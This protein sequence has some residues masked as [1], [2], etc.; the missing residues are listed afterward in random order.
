[1]DVCISHQTALS[2]LLRVPNLRQPGARQ[3][4]AAAIPERVP[5]SDVT[6]KLLDA[7]VGCLPEGHG[8]LDVLV[9]S[10][11]GRYNTGSVRAHLCTTKLPAGSFIPTDAMGVE[12]HVCAPE[13]VFLQMAGEV[14][15]DHLIY[16]GFALC[17][18]FRLDSW[19]P[20]GCVYREGYDAPLTT[21]DRMRAYL[22]RLPEGT[23]NRAVAL[24]ALQHVRAGARSPRE[25]GIAMVIGL[26][27]SL[28]GYSLG[29]TS[30]NPEIRVY[31]GIDSRGEPRWVTR[32]PDILVVAH[33][34]SGRERR[35]G[36]DFDAKSTHGDPL[37]VR[38]DVDRRNLLA[39]VATFT[40]FT[41]GS[42]QVENY[43][44][45]CREIDRIRRALGQRQKPRLVGNADSE[46]NRRLVAATRSRQFDLWNRVLGAECPQL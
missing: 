33:D 35:V 20:G 1:M 14:E 3:S 40:H 30:M 2:Y 7:L 46:R 28:G 26:P 43:V 27:L 18:A 13:L 34:R 37:K 31:D 29:E 17:S 5:R 10:E 22:E 41:L 39:P 24:R 8:R 15:L 36:V 25:V 32:I 38:K 44:A 45:F 11:N 21:V 42:A 19:E 6:R 4:R 12:F 9:S 16:I 23:R